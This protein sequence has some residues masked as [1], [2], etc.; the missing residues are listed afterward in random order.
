[1][2]RGVGVAVPSRAERAPHGHSAVIRRRLPGRFGAQELRRGSDSAEI[3]S[4]CF[5]AKSHFLCVSSDKGTVHI[6]SLMRDEACALRPSPRARAG[7]QVVGLQYKRVVEYL[8][9]SEISTRVPFC[10]AL[11]QAPTGAAKK[12]PS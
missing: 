3:Y 4:L 11:A 7:E 12:N 1:M 2:A 10:I 9:C 8:S 5:D 6:F